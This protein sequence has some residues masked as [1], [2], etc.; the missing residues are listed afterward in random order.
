MIRNE[1]ELKTQLNKL[2][3]DPD[4]LRLQESFEKRK[5]VSIIGF[6]TPRNDA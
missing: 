1:K 5:L 6:W 2:I 3:S 4:F